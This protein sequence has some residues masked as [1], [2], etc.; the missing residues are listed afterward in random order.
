MKTYNYIVQWTDKDNQLQSGM[1]Q[2]YAEVADI[3]KSAEPYEGVATVGK[4][5]DP[6]TLDEDGNEVEG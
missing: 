1:A 3:L 6:I 2:D 4:L 5:S